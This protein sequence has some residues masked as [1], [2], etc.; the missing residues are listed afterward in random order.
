MKRPENGGLFLDPFL[1]LSSCLNL[2]TLFRQ[3]TLH[4]AGPP[5]WGVGPSC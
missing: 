1:S 4:R 5:G 3:H 2:L